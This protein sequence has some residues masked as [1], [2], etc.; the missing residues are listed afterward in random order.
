VTFRAGPRV[1]IK[2]SGDWESAV[3]SII[4]P[5]HVNCRVSSANAAMLAK[6]KINANILVRNIDAAPNQSRTRRG[7]NQ[8]GLSV[9]S[10]DRE[11]GNFDR[12]PAWLNV[13]PATMPMGLACV[14]FSSVI[15]WMLIHMLG[16]CDEPV[17]AV[18]A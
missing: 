2:V 18:L 4:I 12:Q 11:I 5:L 9:I 17:V 16:N 14:A 7:A 6:P 13:T 15:L 3:G 1:N 10:L 8:C